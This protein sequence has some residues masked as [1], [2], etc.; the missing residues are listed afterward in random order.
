MTPKPRCRVAAAIAGTS[1]KRIVDRRLRR[2][3]QRRVGARA[4]HVI[5]AKHVGKKQAVE[6]AAL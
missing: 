2:M 6:Q 1:S 4:E 5:D 3:A